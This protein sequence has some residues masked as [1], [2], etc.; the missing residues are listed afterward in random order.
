MVYKLLGR[1]LFYTD[2]SHIDNDINFDTY[3]EMCIDHSVHCLL[4][5]SDPPFTFSRTNIVLLLIIA[6]ILT[7]L[8]YLSNFEFISLF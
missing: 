5:L 6:I 7:E 3:M 4:S 2:C 8:T 1:I